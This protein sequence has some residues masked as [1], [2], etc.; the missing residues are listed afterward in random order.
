M[1]AEGD[2]GFGGKVGFEGVD[3]EISLKQD[4]VVEGGN[5]LISM[6][7]R[8]EPADVLTNKKRILIPNP[9]YRYGANDAEHEIGKIKPCQTIQCSVDC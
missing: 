5:I 2:D 3:Q 6:V 7:M 1:I 9:Q 8:D 4:A